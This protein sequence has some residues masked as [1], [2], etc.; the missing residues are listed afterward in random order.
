M[1][2][3]VFDALASGAV[4]LSDDVEGLDTLFDGAVPTYSSADDLAAQVERYLEDEDFRLETIAKAR[5][6]VLEHHTF[7]RRAEQLTELIRP[8]LEGREMDCDGNLFAP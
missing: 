4:V 5:H 1:S 2:N 3:R 7:D 6:L 8:L